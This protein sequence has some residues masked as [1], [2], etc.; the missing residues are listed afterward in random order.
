MNWYEEWFDSPLYEFLYAS[1]D[2]KDAN[3]L[4]DLIEEK[5]PLKEYRQIVDVGCGRGRHSISLA[6]RGYRVTGF[7]LSPLAVEKAKKSAKERGLNNVRFRVQDMRVPLQETFDGAVN[8]FTTFGYFMDEKENRDVL[9]SISRML[10]PD[11]R[12]LIDFLNAGRVKRELVPEENGSHNGIDYHIK[13][14]IRNG[15]V[16]KEIE[17]GGRG[18]DTPR[19]YTERVHLFDRD[20][21]EEGLQNAG[22]SIESVMGDY[23]GKPFDEKHSPRL[24]ILSERTV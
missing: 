3:R 18:L 20:W 11:G 1:R 6:E 19:H 15:C 13:R 22:F 8:L 9:K 23:D 4:A 21:M 17:F 24:I 5:I 10:K 14:Y 16:Y 2:E 12:F 7:D